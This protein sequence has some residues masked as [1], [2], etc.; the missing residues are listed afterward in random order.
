MKETTQ[1]SQTEVWRWLQSAQSIVNAVWESTGW[2][3][4]IPGMGTDTAEGMAV[5]GIEQPPEVEDPG[6]FSMTEASWMAGVTPPFTH[7]LSPPTP[8]AHLR[9]TP[10]W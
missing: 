5:I 6:M 1:S 2:I 3:V 9:L 7:H 10:G 8:H 4:L